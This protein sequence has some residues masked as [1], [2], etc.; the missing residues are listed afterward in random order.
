MQRTN[1]AQAEYL[2]CKTFGCT[3]ESTKLDIVERLTVDAI[4]AELERLTYVWAGYETK[5]NDNTNELQVLE[6]EID[7]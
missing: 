5:A 2:I 3:T 6:A 4:Q 1:G 7:I